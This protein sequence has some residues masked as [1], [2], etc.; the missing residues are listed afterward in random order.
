MDFAF[1][2]SSNVTEAMSFEQWV[3]EARREN[4][5]IQNELREIGILV[6]QSTSEVEKLAQRQAQIKNKIQAIDSNLDTQPREYIQE[7]YRASQETQGRLLM[8][9]AQV[10]Q[11]QNKQQFLQRYADRLSGLI[12]AFDVGSGGLLHA[13]G[14]TTGILPKAAHQDMS[15]LDLIDAQESERQTLAQQ[16]HDGPAQSLT[17]LIL[18]AEICER[19]FDKNPQR[20]REE[21][22]GL[23]NEINQTFQK[24]CSYIFDLRP[25][26][27]DDLG[28]LPT[29]KQYL[30]DFEEKTNLACSL[31][32]TGSDERLP[33]HVEITVFRAVQTL[34]GH[35]AQAHNVTHIL[36]TLEQQ[37]EQ[38]SA[39]LEN[40]EG[41]LDLT[42]LEQNPSLGLKSIQRRLELFNGG[43]TFDSSPIQGTIASIWLPLNED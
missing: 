40:K 9:R 41:M 6:Q 39:H 35:I 16:L 21:L 20:A 11:L 31:E 7:T 5:Q 8:M 33:S 12:Q 43:L 37:P 1:M 25:M 32:L 24:V 42:A 3:A 13:Q 15:I 14:G 4:E 27:L 22:G 38:V 34:L 36:L 29:L 19:L 10:E 17:N 28:L 30:R 23:K 18:Q 2:E 26:M